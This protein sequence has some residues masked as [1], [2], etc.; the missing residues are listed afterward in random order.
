MSRATTCDDIMRRLIVGLTCSLLWAQSWAM[1]WRLLPEVGA[2]GADTVYICQLWG[3]DIYEP[4]QSITCRVGTVYVVDLGSGEIRYHHKGLQG[5]PDSR[6]ERDTQRDAL[7]YALKGEGFEKLER[8]RADFLERKNSVLLKAETEK[9]RARY[10]ADYNESTTLEKIAAFEQKYANDDPDGLIPELAPVKTGLKQEAYHAAY[11][12]ATTSQL[13]EKFIET[14]QTEDPE[15]L[16]PQARTRKARLLKQEVALQ[17]QSEK[18]RADEARAQERK[19]RQTEVEQKK[20][21][22]ENIARLNAK[23]GSAIQADSSDG[24]QIVSQFKIDCRTPDR[25]ELPLM[26]VLQVTVQELA[27]LGSRMTFNIQTRG[28]S[29]RIYSDVRKDGKPLGP[30]QLYFEIN[31]WGELRSVAIRNEAVLNSC[32]GSYGPIW[33]LPG[34]LGY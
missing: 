19:A 3:A 18:L 8:L 15:G 20:A 6:Q 1:E 27:N 16:V 9:R 33:L 24:Y 31:E 22:L 13:L 14:Y 23:F 29:V 25:R 26:T 34:E 30:T 21:R 2:T 5:L 32:Y 11:S 17:L 7:A 4:G 28:K 12:G 10:L